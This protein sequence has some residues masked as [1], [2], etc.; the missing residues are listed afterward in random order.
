MFDNGWHAF[1]WPVRQINQVSLNNQN[2]SVALCLTQTPCYVQGHSVQLTESVARVT[3]D[4]NII[5]FVTRSA[6]R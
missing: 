4:F 3:T 1:F 5:I 2:Y 6:L